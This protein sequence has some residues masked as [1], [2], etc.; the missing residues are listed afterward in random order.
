MDG[1]SVEGG[2]MAG[3]SMNKDDGSNNSLPR[4]RILVAVVIGSLFLVEVVIMNFFH[5][6]AETANGTMDAMTLTAVLLPLL[7]FLIYRPLSRSVNDLMAFSGTLERQVR[8][9]TE[10]LGY[11]EALHRTVITSSSDAIARINGDGVI[12]M[13]NSAAHRMFGYADAELENKHISTLLPDGHE[14]ALAYGAAAL[15]GGDVQ[16][17]VRVVEAMAVTRSG[18]KLTVECTSSECLVNN[19]I[20]FVIIMRDVTERKKA[21]EVLRESKARYRQLSEASFEG[22]VI[23]ID[24]KILDVN[25]AFAR[26]FGYAKEEIIGK[27]ALDISPPESHAIIM[28]HIRRK[29]EELYD[30]L[31]LKKD[32]SLF[33][34]EMRGR[35]ILHN[36]QIA[37]ITAV[38]DVTERKKADEALRES[39]ARYR[40]ISEASFEGIVINIAGKVVDC[41]SAFARMFGY[42]PEEIVGK[43]PLDLSPPESHAI[44]MDHI[45]RES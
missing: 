9:R 17:A 5:E 13:A 11:S 12:L 19:E 4:P 21:E 27:T 34:V 31:G 18:R 20:S 39:E 24:G 28:D 1:H 22:I 41:N 32:G 7:Y 29:S 37:R 30:A 14:K 44:I 33:P 2:I 25:D 42:A 35:V 38:R 43:V 23:A 36:G 3:E 6:F 26:M 8:E 16:R 40:L 10:E 15:N 45:R